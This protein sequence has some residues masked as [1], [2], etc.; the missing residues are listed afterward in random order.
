MTF[1]NFAMKDLSLKQ[2]NQTDKR[3]TVFFI[4]LNTSSIQK[5]WYFTLI[6][7]GQYNFEPMLLIRVNSLLLNLAI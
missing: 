4:E 5:D 1:E 2:D 7:N 6:D 3:P